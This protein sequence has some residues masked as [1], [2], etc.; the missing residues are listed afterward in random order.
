M[1]LYCN[2]NDTW[3][4]TDYAYEKDLITSWGKSLGN[5]YAKYNGKWYP[6]LYH[7][8]FASLDP[9]KTSYKIALTNDNLTATKSIG[10]GNNDSISLATIPIPIKRRIYIEFTF[11]EVTDNKCGVGLCVQDIDTN[12]SGFSPT[13]GSYFYYGYNGHTYINGASESAYGDVYGTG[14]TIGIAID[15]VLGYIWFSVNGVWQ[16]GSSIEEVQN[17]TSTHAAF[18]NV[19]GEYFPYIYL[20]G[21]GN[22]VTSNFGEQPYI[23]TV[24]NGF[25][26]LSTTPFQTL[27]NSDDLKARMDAASLSTSYTT[28]QGISS[29]A[30][31]GPIQNTLSGG[32]AKYI[33]NGGT[34]YPYVEIGP[35]F[36]SGVL[37][38]PFSAPYKTISILYKQPIASSTNY[39]NLQYNSTISVSIAFSTN[40]SAQVT[41]VTVSLFNNGTNIATLNTTGYTFYLTEFHLYTINVGPYLKD[42]SI[43]IDGSLRSIPLANATQ[44]TGVSANKL[45]VDTIVSARKADI[46]EIL[47]FDKLLT[48]AEVDELNGGLLSKY[49]MIRGPSF[50]FKYFKVVIS[51][52]ST[53]YIN[54]FQLRSTSSPSTD[55]VPYLASLNDQGFVIERSSY[56]SSVRDAWKMFN[57]TVGVTP[58]DAWGATNANS[59]FIVRCPEFID[60][61]SFSM[62]CHS[63]T[64]APQ[65]VSIYGS[66]SGSFSGEEVQLTN[67]TSLT[68]TNNTAK[69]FTVSRIC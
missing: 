26:G 68:W 12:N 5:I 45:Y 42:C 66:G 21:E 14:T 67:Q 3:R 33:D 15:T 6:I 61:S 20:W 46:E 58:D 44:W 38:H 11:G 4:V 37:T 53:M 32:T 43:Y 23:H 47:V 59:Y 40:A 56:E 49:D 2:Q 25:S 24:P 51:G 18:T 63:A 36:G 39:I 48:A 64:Y 69:I 55:V 27:L 28:G 29:W 19:V 35:N 60:I 10:T 7:I 34:T 17:G 62:T 31:S 54:D 9:N 22:S 1:T 8:T 16:N 41:T 57:S 52:P 65:T 13:V 30:S 50:V